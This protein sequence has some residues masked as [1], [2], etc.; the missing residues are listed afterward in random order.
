MN[1]NMASNFLLETVSL[2]KSFDGVKAVDSV[3]IQ[4][5]ERTITTIIGPNGAGKTTL[6][7]IISGLI[8]EDSGVVRYKDKSLNDTPAW[9][10]SAAGIGRLW[11]DVRL[12]KNMTAMENLL[13]AGRKQ[14]GEKILDLFFQPHKV[15]AIEKE[16]RQQALEILELFGL[17]EKRNTISEDLSYGQQKLIALG[18]LLMNN[19]DLLLLDEPTAGV[20]PVIIEKLLE[21]ILNLVKN[22]KTVLMIEHDVPKAMAISDMIYVMDNG[23]IAL[24]GS[25]SEILS[26]TQ[27]KEIYVG[28]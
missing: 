19:S 9:N 23:R 13:V 1:P 18:R 20:N 6:F 17:A 14:A 5:P 2:S 26:N 7:N 11:Q 10:R 21:H 24:S 16:N 27:L 22:G 12:F 15:G 28:V 3:S 4:I 8:V 25:P